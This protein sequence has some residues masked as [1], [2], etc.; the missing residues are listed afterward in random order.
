[1][2]N[3]HHPMDQMVKDAV[4][5]VVEQGTENASQQ[6]ITLAAF[7]WM[8]DKRT[9]SPS[10]FQKYRGR[11]VSGAGLGGVVVYIAQLLHLIPNGS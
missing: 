8:V 2:G 3:R 1:M 5:R 7:D 10:L 6:D 9:P 11:E 4:E